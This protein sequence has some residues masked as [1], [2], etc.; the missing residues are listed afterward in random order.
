MAATT[1]V[2]GADLDGGYSAVEPWSSPGSMADLRD[3]GVRR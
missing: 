1:E 2:A 3:S